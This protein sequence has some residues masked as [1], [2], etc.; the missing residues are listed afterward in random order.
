LGEGVELVAEELVGLLREAGADAAGVDQLL[1]FV[2]A[3]EEGAHAT[4]SGVA[5]P[6]EGEAAD[7]E[8]LL[9]E[10]L[11]LEPGGGAAGDVFGGGE[12]GDDAFGAHQAGAVED[13]G[14]VGFE[15]VTEVERVRVGG[16]EELSEEGFAV[17]EGKVAGVVAVEVEEVE[18]EV[19][20]VVARAFLKGGL[21]VGEA[22]GAVGGEDH[23]FSVEG[24][25]GCR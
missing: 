25:L 4:H 9:V 6:G 24:A 5:G 17:A 20:E 2:V 7:D 3:E 8:F 19:G 13:R 16:G 18:R 11:A 12:F 1:S 10:A 21:E 23:G 14:A 22:G 15:V